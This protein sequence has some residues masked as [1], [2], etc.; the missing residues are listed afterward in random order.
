VFVKRV[1]NERSRGEEWVL[2]FFST[3]LCFLVVSG[4]ESL[5]L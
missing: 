2:A 4:G 1:R 3:S 5:C